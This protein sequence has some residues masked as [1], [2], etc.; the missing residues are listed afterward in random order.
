[1]EKN[2]DRVET[3]IR[4]GERGTGKEFVSTHESAIARRLLLALGG[5]RQLGLGHAKLGRGLNV[6][7]G[8][9]RDADSGEEAN[10][11]NGPLERVLVGAGVRTNR[12]TR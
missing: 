10:H 1:M 9:E 2:I 11:V 4:V 5:A 8:G 3:A 7:P 12:M 6:H